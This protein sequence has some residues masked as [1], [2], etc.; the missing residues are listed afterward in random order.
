MKL[1]KEIQI[2]GQIVETQFCDELGGKLGKC[3]CYNGYQQM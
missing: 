2:G 1:P 3:C